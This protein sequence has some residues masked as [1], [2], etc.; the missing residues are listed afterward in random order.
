MTF[1]DREAWLMAAADMLGAKVFSPAGYDVPPILV[2]VGFPSRQALGAKT[3]RIG[4]AWPRAA[5]NGTYNTVFISPLLD[6]P[7]KCV[8]VLAHELVHAVDDCE[9]AHRAAFV[10]ICDKV[11]LTEGKP[12]SRGA[13]PELTEI[14]KAIIAELGDF[15]HSP[16]HALTEDKK[17]STRMVKVICPECGYTVRSTMMWL[18]R[19]VPTCP[20]GT[21]MESTVPIPEEPE[22]PEEPEGE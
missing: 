8:D 6:D 4:E 1:S 21:Q 19:G 14:I 11:G 5:S 7:V 10:K 20:C 2:S 16:L 18:K 17:Q 13:G 9:H 12:K 15:P 3:R 22:E